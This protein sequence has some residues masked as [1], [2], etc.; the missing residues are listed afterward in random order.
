MS[1]GQLVEKSEFVGPEI[2]VIAL[3]VRIAPDMARPRR[4]ERQEIGAKRGFVGCAIGPERPTG[5][6]VG[7][8]PFVVRHGILDDESLNPVRMGQGHAKTH[9]APVILHVKSV[10]R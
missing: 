10:A 4:L 7:S 2:R 6:P 1:E 8:Q 3:H 9:G 5:F